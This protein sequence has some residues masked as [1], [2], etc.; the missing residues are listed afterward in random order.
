M[1]PLIVFCV[2]GKELSEQQILIPEHLHL[3]CQMFWMRHCV[4][5]RTA[6]VASSCD[7]HSCTAY[8]EIWW[9][10]GKFHIEKG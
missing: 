7:L 1:F 6:A 10:L 3:S 4:A 8:R 2:Y 9:E 5:V